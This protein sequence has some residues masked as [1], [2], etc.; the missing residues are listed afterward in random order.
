MATHHENSLEKAHNALTVS[1]FSDEYFWCKFPHIT[2]P[3]KERWKLEALFT[4]CSRNSS[5]M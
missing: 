5:N 1:L 2:N 4:E 3:S